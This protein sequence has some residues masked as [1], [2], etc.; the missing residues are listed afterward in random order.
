[1]FTGLVEDVGSIVGVRP[2]GRG[3][4]LL[5]RTG[6]PL[7]EVSI[8]DSIAVNGACLTV[9]TIADDTFD[10]VAGAETIAKTTAGGLRVGSRVHLERAMRLG[11]RLDGHIVQGHVD[12]QGHVTRNTE[13][14]ESWVL[15][16]DVGDAL[17]R[18]VAAKGSICI[19]GVSLTVNEVH[20]TLVRLNIVP[21]TARET[22]LAGL[23]S[24]DRVNVEV[25]I[26]AKYLERLIGHGQPSGLTMEKLQA[27]GFSS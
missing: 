2:E 16:V 18:Y 4:R 17:S 8:G 14:R 12:G 23:H 3:R 20:G 21:H 7:S 26:L 11:G 25:D 27:Y 10:V 6:L 15:W 9:E 13:E 24:G 22:R 1:M 19:D 5:I